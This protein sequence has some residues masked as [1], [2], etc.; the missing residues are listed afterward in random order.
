MM[1]PRG[2]Y[3]NIL[4]I[5]LYC[6]RF[7]MLSDLLPGTIA[8]TFG[9][10]VPKEVLIPL[11]NKNS[12][13]IVIQ[14]LVSFVFT[15]VYISRYTLCLSLTDIVWIALSL[16]ATLFVQG[17]PEKLCPF[18]LL[19]WRSCRFDYVGFLHSYIGQALI[20]RSRLCMS[21]SDT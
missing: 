19:L 14:I 16:I 21:Q 8:V 18:V 4:V 3:V 11:G 5:D 12:K 10:N 1:T 13:N 9:P 17:V 6:N 15:P 20:K 2:F 7:Y